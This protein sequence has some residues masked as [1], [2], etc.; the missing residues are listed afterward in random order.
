MKMNISRRLSEAVGSWLHLEFCCYRAGLMSES[1]L[2]SA[3]GHVLS[4]F[5]IKTE[6]ARV[7]ADYAHDAL[8]RNLKGRGRARSVD[9]ALVLSTQ[10]QP[11]SGAE[12]LVEVKWV[13][14]SHAKPENIARDFVRLA[15]LKA[16]EPAATCV[17]LLAGQADIL[18]K[19]LKLPPFVFDGRQNSGI[20]TDIGKER[21]L[22]LSA[23]APG[24]RRCLDAAVKKLSEAGCKIPD[25]FVTCSHGLYP[26]LKKKGAID[27]QAVAWEIK[28]PSSKWIDPGR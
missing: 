13:N 17:F 28:S 3:V 11:K 9:F 22:K 6:G 26:V 19:T 10:E 18:E 24:D 27:F 2:K 20:S 4:S 15:V 14:S 8:N 7:Y 1:S 16:A 25:S 21:R 12:V 5:P 23:L